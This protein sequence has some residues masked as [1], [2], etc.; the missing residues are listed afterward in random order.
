MEPVWWVTKDGDRACLE[1]YERHYS[2]YHYKDGRQRKLFCG[3]GQKIV[4]RTL[5][6]DVFL[7]GGFIDDSG[8]KGTNCARVSKRI[9]TQIIG[10]YPTGL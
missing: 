7:Y 3:P 1:M 6:A 5:A 10:A 4:L 2:A 9:N 8:Q